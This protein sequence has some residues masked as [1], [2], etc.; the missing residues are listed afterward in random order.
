MFCSPELF[1]RERFYVIGA[2]RNKY[3]FLR[4]RL[5]GCTSEAITG[6][7]TSAA[8]E[9]FQHNGA[10]LCSPRCKNGCVQQSYVGG[11]SLRVM[12]ARAARKDD[13]LRR[14]VTFAVEAM[15]GKVFFVLLLTLNCL[16]Q[17][18][19]HPLPPHQLLPA[20]PRGLLY[21]HDINAARS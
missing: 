21:I 3:T 18:P 7:Y 1:M 9:S 17:G 12:M 14:R 13:N 8:S 10:F 11:R 20:L 6:Y 15:G 19:A 5:G 16:F 2:W 4:L